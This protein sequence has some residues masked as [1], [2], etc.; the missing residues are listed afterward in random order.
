M[1]LIAETPS[2]SWRH[3]A[4][5]NGPVKSKK[6]YRALNGHIGFALPEC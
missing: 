2:N 1:N 5:I 6:I 3:T 4:V